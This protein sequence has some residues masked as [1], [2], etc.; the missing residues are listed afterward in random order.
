M[1]AG[2]PCRR[3]A[4]QDRDDL[5]F[6]AVFAGGAHGEMGVGVKARAEPDR[7]AA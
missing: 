1:S 4:V 7:V 6:G 5:G 2:H 3:G